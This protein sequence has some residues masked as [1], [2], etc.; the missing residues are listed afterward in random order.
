[1]ARKHFLL[2][3]VCY[4]YSILQDKIQNRKIYIDLVNYT[5]GNNV[6][7]IIHHFGQKDG[8]RGIDYAIITIDPLLK[9]CIAIKIMNLP[10]L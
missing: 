8:D 10:K 5:K 2:A 6:E 1:L 3:I 7:V 4:D 9:E